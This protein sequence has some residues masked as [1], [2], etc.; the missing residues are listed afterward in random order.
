VTDTNLFYRLTVVNEFRATRATINW[1]SL[2]DGRIMSGDAFTVST[3]H[4]GYQLKEDSIQIYL[5]YV[6]ILDTKNKQE[7]KNCLN[8]LM[9]ECPKE[10]K[11]EYEENGFVLV[12][13]L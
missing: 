3:K 12:E 13:A 8:R 4:R 9:L 2:G 10:A 11:R 5:N 1:H 6:L 7:A